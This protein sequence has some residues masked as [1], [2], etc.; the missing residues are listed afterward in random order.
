MVAETK[1]IISVLI[2]EKQA[3]QVHVGD[4]LRPIYY[5][6]QDGKPL[7]AQC[8][9]DMSV[10]YNTM[11]EQLIKIAAVAPEMAPLAEMIPPPTSFLRKGK[12]SRP[13]MLQF[14]SPKVKE[15]E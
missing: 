6:Q 3:V 14:L 5:R 9:K 1:E 7:Y 8:V 12:P 2:G 4:R 10:Q 15:E 11:R 13:L